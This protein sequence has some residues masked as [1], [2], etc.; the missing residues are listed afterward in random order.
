MRLKFSQL[1]LIAP[2]A[3]AYCNKVPG[4]LG[5]PARFA[6]CSVPNSTL[7]SLRN[8][9]LEDPMLLAFLTTIRSRVVAKS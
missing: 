2:P 9:H 3:A 7:S 8:R 6:L 5:Y 1:M 4:A